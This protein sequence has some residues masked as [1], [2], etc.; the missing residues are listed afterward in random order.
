[1]IG[2]KRLRV[3]P[4][5]RPRR[6]TRSL[7]DSAMHVEKWEPIEGISAPCDHIAFSYIPL[8]AAETRM[9]FAATAGSGPRELILRFKQV[10]VLSGED[11]CPGGFVLAPAINSLPKLG[12]GAH[13]TWT[14]P[15]F[16]IVES[17]P[18]KNYQLMRPQKIAHF[19]MV[20]MD[21]LV[22]VIASADVDA[23]WNTS[24]RRS[25]SA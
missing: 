6:S 3:T 22:H 5:P 11:E 1:M 14:F 21:N 24:I 18:L 9:T 16:K 17:E 2:I 10:V 8:H 19:F 20:S 13:P 25:S 4:T 12:R 15:L 7:G 23:A